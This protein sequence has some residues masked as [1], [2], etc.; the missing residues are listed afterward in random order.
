MCF[1][2]ILCH[3]SGLNYQYNMPDYNTYPNFNTN[4]F[5]TSKFEAYNSPVKK[6]GEPKC[7]HFCPYVSQKQNTPET[8]SRTHAYIRRV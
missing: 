6:C 1:A 7:P 4:L 2:D 8:Y 5:L 3:N